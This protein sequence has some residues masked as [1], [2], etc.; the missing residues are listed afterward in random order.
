MFTT[1]MKVLAPLKPTFPKRGWA[2]AERSLP[3]EAFSRKN[4]WRRRGTRNSGRKVYRLAAL[5]VCSVA[6]LALLVW[7]ILPAPLDKS[8]NG[9]FAQALVKAFPE[10]DAARMTLIY[11]EVDGLGELPVSATLHMPAFLLG[12]RE[13]SDPFT[14]LGLEFGG[15][16]QVLSGAELGERVSRVVDSVLPEDVSRCQTYEIG[17]ASDGEGV[18]TRALH[19]HLNPGCSSD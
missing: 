3:Q 9:P 13:A 7:S 18:S 5:G 1:A 6:G 12:S 4:R 16:K 8:L 11:G 14:R 19:L 2:G 10:A 15:D 17:E